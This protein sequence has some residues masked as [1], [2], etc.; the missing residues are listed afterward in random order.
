MFCNSGVGLRAVERL[1]ARVVLVLGAMVL[2]GGVVGVANGIRDN[3]V[4][5][6][7]LRLLLMLLVVLAMR[8]AAPRAHERN[9]P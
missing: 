2:L 6:P 1:A 8:R 3:E 5:A 7:L 9:R 4:V